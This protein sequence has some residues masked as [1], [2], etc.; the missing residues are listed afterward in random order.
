MRE[1]DILICVVD[2]DRSVCVALKRLLNAWGF[3]VDTFKSAEEFLD[4]GLFHSFGLLILDVR[5]AGMSGLEL[6]KRLTEKNSDAP[7]IFV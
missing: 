5:M 3:H 6:Q 4:S 2:D 1:K 7:V